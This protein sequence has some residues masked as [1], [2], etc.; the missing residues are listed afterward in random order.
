VFS[1]NQVITDSNNLYPTAAFASNVAVAASNSAYTNANEWFFY[2]S[3]L[4]TTCNV[5]IGGFSN[6]NYALDAGSNSIAASNIYRN[7]YAF[8]YFVP[9][10]TVVISSNYSPGAAT[11]GSNNNPISGL[12]AF[13][14]NDATMPYTTIS[15]NGFR[16]PVKGVYMF[17]VN[18]GITCRA[19][20]CVQVIMTSAPSNRGPLINRDTLSNLRAYTISTAETWGNYFVGNAS[21]AS[22]GYIQPG[23]STISFNCIDTLNPGDWVQVSLLT[24]MTVRSNSGA[25]PVLVQS[26][27]P[28][29]IGTA[30]NNVVGASNPPTAYN[31]FS[32]CLIANL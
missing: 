30:S 10:N 28:V 29:S 20:D 2:T 1:S 4:Y 15:S 6:A 16:A 12:V 11:I 5:A 7:S 18:L 9:V 26:N 25:T 21:A 23:T 14:S 31:Y 19:Y 17:T 13:S 27:T 8:R 32:G 22:D 24:H 3:N